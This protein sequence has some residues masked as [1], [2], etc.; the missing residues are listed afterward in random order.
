MLLIKIDA[1]LAAVFCYLISLFPYMYNL[2]RVAA[3]IF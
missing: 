2:N 3:K 1:V